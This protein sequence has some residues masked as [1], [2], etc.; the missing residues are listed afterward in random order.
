MHT[1]CPNC[2]GDKIEAFFKIK[3]APIFS[4]V[5]VKTKEEA[6]RV[7]RKDI[8]L[9]F[10]H[11]CGFIFNRLFDTTINYFSMG[12]EDQQGFSKT[13]MKYLT[14]ISKKLIEKH[15]L[16]G[17]TLLEI[18]CGKGDFINLL[19]EIAGGKG[20]GIDPAYEF[21]RQTNPNLSFF[22]EFYSL[23]HGKIPVDLICCRH[24]L[25]HIHQP[26]D[27]LNLIRSSLENS[28]SA[29]VF[30]EIPQI[31]RILDT[32]AF[33]DIYY[34]HCSYFSAG[35]LSHL[36]TITGYEIIDIRLDYDD[37]YLLIEAKPTTTPSANAFEIKESIEDQKVR[38]ENFKKAI[39]KQL[40]E[41][42]DRLQMMKDNGKKT[43]VWGGGSKAVGFLTNF[44]D[45]DF[46][47]YVVDINPNMENNYIP[48]V[49]CRYIQ[50]PFLKEYQPNT[51]IIM[52]GVYK[53]EIMKSINDMGIFPEVFIL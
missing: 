14:R 15:D 12:Y 53:D 44:I 32:C 13:F 41:W 50:P 51:I 1:I 17:K 6:L 38:I 24:T 52:N 29:I 18:G 3:N 37:Q 26:H 35:S 48:G 40:R 22:K 11:N 5:T 39:D 34:E 20:I 27:F 16:A 42:R 9:G 49:G 2:K 45:L 21:G 25:E 7:P 28:P 10:C 47:E 23:E 4:M 31:N 30:F 43:V 46:I 19:T 36:F 33:W 8:E